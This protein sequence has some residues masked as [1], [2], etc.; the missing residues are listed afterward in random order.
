MKNSFYRPLYDIENGGPPRAFECLLCPHLLADKSRCRTVAQVGR[1]ITVTLHGMHIH[2]KR[3]HGFQWQENL[4]IVADPEIL[5][6][7]DDEPTA[8]MNS[9]GN[10]TQKLP[11][12]MSN[13]NVD[14]APAKRKIEP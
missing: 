14:S 5:A 11:K 12:A 13:R 7:T 1:T 2:L 4:F 8:W 10:I 3:H 6:Y 9:D